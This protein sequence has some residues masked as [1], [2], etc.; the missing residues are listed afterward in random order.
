MSADVLQ[1]IIGAILASNGLFALLQFLI[2]RHDTRKN[3]NGKLTTLEKDGLRTQLLLLLLMQR[4]EKSEILTIAEHYFK[5]P[6]E[7]GL[8]GNWYMTSLFSK[9]CDEHKIEPEW[10]KRD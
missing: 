2:T 7:G 5:K 1:I 10:F 4:E 3:V 9:W 6:S 8:G